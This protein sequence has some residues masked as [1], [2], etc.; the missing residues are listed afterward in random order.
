MWE[1][2]SLGPSA[3]ANSQPLSTQSTFFSPDTIK[4]MK[5]HCRA[6]DGQRWV[7]K[8]T[9]SS[10]RAAVNTQDLTAVLSGCCGTLNIHPRSPPT[11]FPPP[12]PLSPPIPRLRTLW[13]FYAEH[14]AH[15]CKFNPGNSK[16]GKWI[17]QPALFFFFYSRATVSRRIFISLCSCKGGLRQSGRWKPTAGTVWRVLFSQSLCVDLFIATLNAWL[18]EVSAQF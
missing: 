14:K 15:R 17:L 16:A 7:Q 6:T 5:P 12:L 4:R 3:T 11:V 13:R 1:S 8:S 18:Q 10:V 2:P 9:A